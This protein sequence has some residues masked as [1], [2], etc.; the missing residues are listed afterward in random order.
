MTGFLIRLKERCQHIDL[1]VRNALNS[2]IADTHLIRVIGTATIQ[3]G[4]CHRYAGF[5]T[6][7]YRHIHDFCCLQKLDSTGNRIMVNNAGCAQSLHTG[8]IHSRCGRI[9][10]KRIRGMNVVVYVLGHHRRKYS[11]LTDLFQVGKALFLSRCIE[12]IENSN[13]NHMTRSFTHSITFIVYSV[14]LPLSRNNARFYTKC[15]HLKSLPTVDI[16]I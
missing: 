6:D 4:S 2:H 9:G 5:H 14:T 10:R 12:F 16:I 1:I 13:I 11:F 3:S 8:G 15:Y 7:R